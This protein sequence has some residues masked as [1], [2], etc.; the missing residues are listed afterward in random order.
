[1]STILMIWLCMWLCAALLSTNFMEC[2]SKLLA[3]QQ[4]LVSVFHLMPQVVA[5]LGSEMTKMKQG[6]C[7]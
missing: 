1:M 2:L 6:V 4:A 5:R 3:L 7:P